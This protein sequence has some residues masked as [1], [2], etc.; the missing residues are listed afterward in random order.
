[1]NNPVTNVAPAPLAYVS[2]WVFQ[3]CPNCGHETPHVKGKKC[4]CQRCGKAQL[5]G[6]EGR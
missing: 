1:M 3:F 4:T 5:S 6:S 2:P